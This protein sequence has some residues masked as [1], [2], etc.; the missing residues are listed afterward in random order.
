V[1]NPP[2]VRRRAD[3]AL[4][5]DKH[6]SHQARIPKKTTLRRPGR[7][8]P[9]RQAVTRKPSAVAEQRFKKQITPHRNICV[10]YF[11]QWTLVVGSARVKAT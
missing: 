8:H 2:P 11:G 9:G 4:L 6:L 1:Y 10:A 3:G 5:E 7:N